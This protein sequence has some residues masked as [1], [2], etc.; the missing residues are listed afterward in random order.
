V[1]LLLPLCRHAAGAMLV[2]F[3]AILP[4]AFL[5][6]LTLFPPAE[7]GTQLPWTPIVGA[8]IMGPV[9]ALAI[10]IGIR[11]GGGRGGG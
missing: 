10:R 7:W 4:Y 3:V 9:G 5:T 8:A 6:V 1:G 11:E 2:G